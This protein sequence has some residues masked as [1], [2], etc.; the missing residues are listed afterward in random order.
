LFSPAVT[1]APGSPRHDPQRLARTY[2]EIL[3]GG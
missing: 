2:A 1:F 3:N